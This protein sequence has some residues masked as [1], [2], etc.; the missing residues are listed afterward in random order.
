MAGLLGIAVFC[1][2]RL[3]AWH[4]AASQGTQ[5]TPATAPAI[6]PTIVTGFSPPPVFKYALLQI[7]GALLVFLTLFLLRQWL[8][9]SV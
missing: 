9:F 5:A 2:H 6:H 1:I 4:A 7:P 3:S 8:H